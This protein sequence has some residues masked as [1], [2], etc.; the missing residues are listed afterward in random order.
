MM[1]KYKSM[2]MLC[3]EMIDFLHK[4]PFINEIPNDKMKHYWEAKE[5]LDKFLESVK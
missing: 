4:G 1:N 3:K 5:S 2:E